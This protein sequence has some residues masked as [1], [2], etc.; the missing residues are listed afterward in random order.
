M[1]ICVP[2]GRMRVVVVVCRAG[3]CRGRGDGEEALPPFCCVFYV[4]FW[5]NL[6]AGGS[7][8]WRSQLAGRWWLGGAAARVEAVDESGVWGKGLGSGNRGEAEG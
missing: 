8:V 3:G 4:V 6:N 5:K 2:Q 1:H 7:F